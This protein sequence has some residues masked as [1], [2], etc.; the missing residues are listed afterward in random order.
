M[1]NT[2]VTPSWVTK[3]T[4][5]GY[6]NNLIFAANLTKEYNDQFVVNGVKMGD[7][8]NVRL[9]QRFV[10][11]HGQALVLQNIFDQTVPVTL[12]D[13]VNVG[14]NYSSAQATT[15]IDEVRRR[16]VEPAAQT[17]A[18]AADISAYS[19]MFYE[20]YSSVGTPGTAPSSVQTYLDA[21]T[22][23]SDL[24]VD[25]NGRKAVLST[26]HMATIAGAVSTLFNPQVV[27]SSTYRK[28]M[29]GQE[30]LGIEEWFQSQSVQTYTTGSFTA[31]TPLVNGANQTGSSLITN[32]WASGATTLKKGDIF[33]IAGVYT[34]NPV[35]YQTVNS[36]Q[37]FVV[38]AT[39]SDSTGDM[40]IP[41]SPSIIASGQLQNVSNVPASG[42][43][44]TVVGSTG[45]VGGTL[46]AT[47]STQSLVYTEDFGMLATAD[48]VTPQGGADFS[49]VR[50]KEWGISIRWVRQYQIGSDQN[51]SRFDILIGPAVLQARF[52]CRVQG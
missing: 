26:K 33:T 19:T 49:F 43:A 50:D 12:N 25:V 30:Q 31:S 21:G 45:A 2:L 29:F 34:V 47:V 11:N 4:A 37:Q 6:I 41:I 48:L 40:T 3:E 36:L 23:L 22:K 52:A 32:G 39:T 18:N 10:A 51:D 42:A 16:Y 24:S 38:T 28:G 15:Q 7:T 8:I 1:A 46:S 5:A 44:I 9:P 35:G 20:V 13:Q 27:Q 14:F 17:L